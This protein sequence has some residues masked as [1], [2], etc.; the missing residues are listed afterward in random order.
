MFILTLEHGNTSILLGWL[1]FDFQRITPI[2]PFISVIQICTTGRSRIFSRN[3]SFHVNFEFNNFSRFHLP[4][5]NRHLSSQNLITCDLSRFH[6][7]LQLNVTRFQSSRQTNL[8]NRSEKIEISS[9]CDVTYH[10]HCH[11]KTFIF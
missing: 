11:W 2:F 10:C 4:K 7:F 1:N 3:A 8:K 9:F 5:I 6:Q